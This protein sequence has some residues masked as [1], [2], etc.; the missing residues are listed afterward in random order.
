[1]IP[2]ALMELEYTRASPLV[3]SLVSFPAQV[4]RSFST[5]AAPPKAEP[6]WK[7]RV[8]QRFSELRMLPFGWD[9]YNAAPISQSVISFA[10]SVLE[11]VMSSV[12]PT[13]S[14][15]PAHGGAVQLEWHV[16]GTDIELMIY[17]PFDGELTVNFADDREDVEEQALTPDFS[18]LAR[19][20]SALG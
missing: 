3:S 15:V 8:E 5:L 10:G 11:S 13:P 4:G 19:E 6:K 20:L 18:A 16:G 9:G 12:T 2:E 17:A 14:I 1:M 7:G